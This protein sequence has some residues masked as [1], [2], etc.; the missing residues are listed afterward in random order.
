MTILSLDEQYL[1]ER[2]A[3][4]KPL[5]TGEGTEDLLPPAPGI[6]LCRCERCEYGRDEVMSPRLEW[7]FR[8]V[9]PRDRMGMLWSMQTIGNPEAVEQMR[10]DFA[11]VGVPVVVLA[12]V[13]TAC[14]AALGRYFYVE[15]LGEATNGTDRIHIQQPATTVDASRLAPLESEGDDASRHTAGAFPY[16]P[17]EDADDIPHY[18]GD[19][20]TRG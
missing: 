6:Y 10:R 12:D 14:E 2:N 9:G 13:K 16:G 4:L 5:A 19:A 15:Y 18:G 1:R 3:H 11:V 20:P 7:A 17:V 8:V